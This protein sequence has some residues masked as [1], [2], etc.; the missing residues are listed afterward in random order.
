[1]NRR[2]LLKSAALLAL[3]YPCRRLSAFEATP[4]FTADPFSAGVAS[5]DP[6]S[7]GVVLWTRLMPDKGRERDWQHETVPI[8]WQIASDESMNRIVKRGREIA[9]PAYRHSI[10]VDVNGLEPGRWYWYRFKS[11]TAISEVGRTKTAPSGASD[12][13]RFAFASCQ[14]Y[15]AGYYTAYQ[16]MIKEDLDAIVFLGD[17]IYERGGN[18][19]RTLPATECLT[20]DQYRD[21]YAL[22][23]SDVNLREAHRLFPWIITWDDH[24]VDNNYAGFSAEDDE[25]PEA[26]K[27][28]RAAAY[29]AHYEWL[30]L[31]KACMP[32]GAYSTMY[33]RLSFGPLANFLVLDGRQYRSDQACGDGIKAPC[34]ESTRPGR[35]MLGQA[36][37]RWLDRELRST[38]SRWNIIAN[39]VRMTVVD[40][41]P[42]PGETY[43]MD[44]WAGY[45]DARRR[46]VANLLDSKAANPV[47]I[48]GDIHSNWVGDLKLDYRELRSPV[49]APEI[50]GTSISTGGDGSDSI[51]AIE[52]TFPD[53]PQ[54]KF[55]NSQRGYVRCE[56]T[57][58]SL[59]ADFRVVQKVSVP[60][61]PASTRASFV[62]EAG[63]PAAVRQS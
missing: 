60:E 9:Q 20:L 3:G 25:S 4:Q 59:T 41:M 61:S 48:T 52:A 24:E 2:S 18:G 30:P 46:F 14:N 22:Y 27:K 51:A 53:N 55:Y 35:T 45:D 63:R 11:G 40:Q 23:R 7:H 1:M 36:Q 5:G 62:V 33:R 10:H 50:I 56:V 44:Q 28:R 58:T 39:Q 12:K 43:A 37:E 16:N 29:Q 49:V 17:Y 32:R 6:S 38:R 15:Q 8:E 21:H 13:L 19:P 31:P 42:G 54:I 47:V 26:F 57:P 34:E